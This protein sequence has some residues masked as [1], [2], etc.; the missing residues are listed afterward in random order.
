M[1]NV[2]LFKGSFYYC[3]GPEVDDIKNKTDCLDKG[4]PYQWVNRKYHFDNLGRV[5]HLY[6]MLIYSNIYFMQH[7]FSSRQC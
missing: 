1:Y 2:Q 5:W 4:P 3:K 6:I 7:T